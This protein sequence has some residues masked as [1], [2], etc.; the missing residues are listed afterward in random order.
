MVLG[1]SDL[2]RGAGMGRETRLGVGACLG[3]GAHWQSRAMADKDKDKDKDQNR[4]RDRDRDKGKDRDKDRGTKTETKTEAQR[5]R[6]KDRDKD[7]HRD[8]DTAEGARLHGPAQ[9]PALKVRRK[10]EG[11]GGR[12]QRTRLF[13]ARLRATTRPASPQRAR[14]TP[15]PP[16]LRPVRLS[17]AS[18]VFVQYFKWFKR[19][20]REP[21][22][23]RERL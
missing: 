2:G 17:T 12:R 7:K 20:L 11:R 18:P 22:A 16:P 5:Q 15:R 8:K 19:S 6:H 1:G 9:V 23:A 14:P 4:D 10:V 21:P 3:V 13:Q